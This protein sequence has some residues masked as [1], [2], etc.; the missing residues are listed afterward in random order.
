MNCWKNHKDEVVIIATAL[1]VDPVPRKE[2]NQV[3]EVVVIATAPDNPHGRG[4][5]NNF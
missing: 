5:H 3:D 2:K 4:G 1:L